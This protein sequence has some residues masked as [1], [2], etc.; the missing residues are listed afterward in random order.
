MGDQNILVFFGE[1]Q[2][3]KD[4]GANFISG[5]V[6]REY[7]GL[8]ERFEIDPETGKLVT[9][10]NTQNEKGE[11]IKGEAILDFEQ[12]WVDPDLRRWLAANVWPYVKKYSFADNLKMACMKIFGLTFEQCY[13][14]DDDKNT[15]TKILWSDMFKFLPDETVAEL[16]DKKHQKMTAREVMQYF[17]TDVCRGLMDECWVKSTFDKIKEE[18]VPFALI[19]DGRFLNELEYSNRVDAKTLFL[20]KKLET[21]TTHASEQAGQLPKNQ[22]SKIIANANMDIV[23]KNLQLLE[24]LGEWGWINWTVTSQ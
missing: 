20:E 21:N 2:S 17:G 19:S 22:F 8:M 7:A 14:S 9:S 24:T 6:M 4:S 13:G 11:T 10:V 1:K 12:H 23:A 3:G 16:G 5:W 18:G 15:E